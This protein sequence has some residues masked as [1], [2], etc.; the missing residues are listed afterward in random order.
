M[1]S[2][3][4]NL[5]RAPLLKREQMIETVCVATFNPARSL[6]RISDNWT[7]S[8]SLLGNN[9]HGCLDEMQVAVPGWQLKAGS[10]VFEILHIRIFGGSCS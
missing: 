4:P 1:K 5:A 3:I 8:G 2:L 10:G 7:N 6:G 9:L